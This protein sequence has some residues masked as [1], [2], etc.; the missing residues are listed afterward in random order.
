MKISNRRIA[1]AIRIKREFHAHLNGTVA[2]LSFGLA[3]GAVASPIP[4]TIA[5]WSIIMV[6]I[7][8]LASG[9]NIRRADRKLVFRFGFIKVWTSHLSLDSL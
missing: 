8:A 2:I 7:A 3:A 1:D 6:T 5:T 9:I 4:A